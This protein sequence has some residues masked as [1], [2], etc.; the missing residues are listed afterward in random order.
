MGPSG[1]IWSE[2]R[3]QHL[4]PP[5]CFSLAVFAEPNLPALSLGDQKLKFKRFESTYPKR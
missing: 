3:P 1:V 4:V 2:F 5:I